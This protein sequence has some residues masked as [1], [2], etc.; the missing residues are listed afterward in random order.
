MT[1][2]VSVWVV[3]W[4]APS[5]NNLT[6]LEA[7]VL[8]GKYL[9]MQSSLSTQRTVLSTSKQHTFLFLLILFI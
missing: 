4:Q 7:I 6:N 3:S 9:N 5:A 8:E 1:P 2:P